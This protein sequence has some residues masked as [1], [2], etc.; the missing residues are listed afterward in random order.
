MYLYIVVSFTGL[1]QS[2]VATMKGFVAVHGIEMSAPEMVLRHWQHVYNTQS[3]GSRHQ[4]PVCSGDQLHITLSNAMGRSDLSDQLEEDNIMTGYEAADKPSSKQCCFNAGPASQTL[5]QNLN[6]VGISW[7]DGS[8]VNAD[9]GGNAD[10]VFGEDASEPEL[11]PASRAE[12]PELV[13]SN[14][15]PVQAS[16]VSGHYD[17]PSGANNADEQ[18][19]MLISGHYKVPN[20][21]NSDGEQKHVLNGIT[22]ETDAPDFTT[23]EETDLKLQDNSDDISPKFTS[24]KKGSWDIMGSAPT[25]EN[26][27]LVRGWTLLESPVT[28]GAAGEPV[29]NGN[30]GNGRDSWTDRSSVESEDSVHVFNMSDPSSGLTTEMSLPKYQND[31]ST[32]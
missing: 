3:E 17:V 4:I 28:R 20:H 2:A 13:L 10:L 29:V 23:N 9:G 24:G 21:S 18:K 31:T 5:D 6:N 8:N 32:V 16:E 11:L 7:A 1:S 15:E 30:N 12:I 26:L 19:Q 22:N 14:D 27:P 25:T